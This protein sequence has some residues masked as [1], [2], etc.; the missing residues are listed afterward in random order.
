[1]YEKPTYKGLNK[2][3][4]EFRLSSLSNQRGY[5]YLANYLRKVCE[6]EENKRLSSG[7]MWA[8]LKPYSVSI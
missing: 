3:E 5:K 6:W 2:S 7:E 4:L 8:T 1:M